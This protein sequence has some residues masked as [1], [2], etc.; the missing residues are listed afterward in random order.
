MRSSFLAFLPA[1]I[2]S[3]FI[4][5]FMG[6]YSKSFLTLYYIII[7]GG[8]E[9]ALSFDNAVVNAKILSKLSKF[10][11]TMF[12]WI[13][14]PIAVFGMRFVFP[15]LLVSLTSSL[16]FIEVM[17]QAFYD[18]ELYSKALNASMPLI[19]GF[20]SCFLLMVF[21]SFL[22]EYQAPNNPHNHDNYWIGFIE[23]SKLVLWLRECKLAIALIGVLICII[24]WLLGWHVLGVPNVGYSALLGLVIHQVLYYINQALGR[25]KST[26]NT[27]ISGLMGF[28]Y[29]EVLDASFSF[30][31]VLGAFAITSDII[32]IFTGLAIGALYVRS[33]TVYLV[34]HKVLSKIKYLEHGAFYAIG[35]LAIILFLKLF[36]HIPEWIPASVSIMIILLAI[37]SSKFNTKGA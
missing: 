32:I 2:I 4:L 28:C 22:F 37:W 7:L 8:L 17:H 13:G 27:F 5:I 29:L 12:L 25:E 16:S 23:K 36:I 20:G 21:V 9:I 24:F 30:D 14:L 3:L 1:T 26:K 6:F 19:S 18:P 33:M 15:V 34:K 31:G 11:V 10:W 35:F